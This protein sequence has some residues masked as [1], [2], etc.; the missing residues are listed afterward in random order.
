MSEDGRKRLD[1][2]LVERGLA[3]TRARARDAILRGHV[4]VD[5][6]AAT[7]PAR[8]VPAAAA[9]TVDDPATAYVSRGGLKLAAALDAFLFPVAGVTAIDIGASTG[10]FTQVLLERGASRVFAIDVGH[11]QLAASLKADPRVVSREGLNA[12]DLTAGDIAGPIGAVVADV[13]FISLRLVLPPALALT[14]PGAWG[15]F[16][17][18]AA[19]RGRPR[20]R[21]ARAASS[22]DAAL[23]E[24]RRRRTSQRGSRPPSAGASLASSPRRSPAA[25]A[26]ANSC[27]RPAVAETVTIESLGAG[28]DGVAETADGR[29][30]VPYTLPGETVEIERTG[31]RARLLQIIVGSPDRIA[32][33]SPH[34][35]VCGGCQ[36][37]HLAR[38]AYHAWKRAVVVHSLRLHGIEAEVEPIH[39]VMPGS[40]RRAV[41]S[42]INHTEGVALGFNQR[43]GETIVPLADCPVLLPSIVSRL[44]ALRDMTAIAVKPRKRA[45]ITVL[46]ADN[47]LDIAITG[48]GALQRRALVGLGAHASDAGIAHGLSVDGTT[49]FLNR[50]PEITIGNATLLPPPAGF[51]QAVTAAET[52]LMAAAIIAHVGG[53]GPVADLFLGGIGTFSLRLAQERPR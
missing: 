23:A 40:R 16:L 48:A 33:A 31:D 24:Q 1:L 50:V 14:L 44:A 46:A 42:A 53:D 10:G 45:R 32:P 12:R 5:G 27:S 26:I 47:G 25:T 19:V 36:V 35:G 30:F 38:A 37:Q 15:V 28:G 3:A 52:Q 13:S 7:R 11:G 4:R 39:P 2:A 8:A 34:F 51:V 22:R 29:V 43:G 6:T 20:R 18:E 17:V 41:F 9:I 49:I 21:R